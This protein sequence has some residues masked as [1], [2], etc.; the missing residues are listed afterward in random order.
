[1][2]ALFGGPEILQV[3]AVKGLMF[4]VDLVKS[5]VFS[6]VGITTEMTVVVVVVVIVII[7]SLLESGE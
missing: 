3:G 7:L 2:C 4:I 5:S 6:L 1:M